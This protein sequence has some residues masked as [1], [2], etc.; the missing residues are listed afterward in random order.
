MDVDVEEVCVME[1]GGVVVVVDHRSGCDWLMP[2]GDGEFGS[3]EV[4]GAA[5]GSL[6]RAGRRLVEA[7]IMVRDDSGSAERELES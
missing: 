4:L 3:A 6:R 1:I 7:N 2:A 5:L